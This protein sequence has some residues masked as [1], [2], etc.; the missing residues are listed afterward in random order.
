MLRRGAKVM[1]GLT[2]NDSGFTLMRARRGHGPAG[3]PL[4]WGGFYVLGA[5]A[6]AA[7]ADARHTR[8]ASIPKGKTA[9]PLRRGPRGWVG[10]GPVPV[11]AVHR[12]VPAGPRGPSRLRGR[13]PPLPDSPAGPP[14]G[15]RQPVPHRLRPAGRSAPRR[16]SPHS[17]RRREGAPRARRRRIRAPGATW[18]AAVRWRPAG[19]GG[20]PGPGQ[21]APRLIPHPSD[22]P[23]GRPAGPGQPAQGWCCMRRSMRPGAAAG[24]RLCCRP[25]MIGL[26]PE[27]A[28]GGTRA[29]PGCGHGGGGGGVSSCASA[30]VRACMRAC[31]RVRAGRRPAGGG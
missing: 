7:A 9:G 2:Q 27:Q 26:R 21:A 23:A 11:I 17:L 1:W 20:G 29:R 24:L 13:R 22:A 30:C 6:A 25:L 5:A 16:S 4:P 28:W 18:S 12:P 10:A 15:P 8:P 19:P 14:P 3:R 31:M